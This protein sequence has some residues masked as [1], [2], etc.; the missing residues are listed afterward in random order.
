MFC[1]HQDI[2]D[3]KCVCPPGFKGDGVKSCEGEKRTFHDQLVMLLGYLQLLYPYLNWRF[4]KSYNYSLPEYHV[5]EAIKWAV[6]SIAMIGGIL[7]SFLLDLG[8]ICIST[9][10][11]MRLATPTSFGYDCLIPLCAGAFTSMLF[12]C[13]YCWQSRNLVI[14]KGLGI[15]WIHV[16]YRYIFRVPLGEIT[17]GL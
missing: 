10:K 1:C 17:K 15:P 14:T 5:H 4:D 6:Y 13:Q 9:M 8:N 12:C 2:G 7:C 3:S 11:T 16:P